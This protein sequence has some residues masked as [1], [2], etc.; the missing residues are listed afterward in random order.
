[1]ENFWC[2]ERVTALVRRQ[3]GRVTWSQLMALGVARSTASQWAATGRLTR[4]LPHVYA[5]GPAIHGPEAGRWEAALYAGP[6]AA[7]S[8]RTAAHTWGLIK[9]PPAAIEVST[10]RRKPSIEGV[11]RVYRRRDVMRTTY[12]GVPITTVAQTL[13]DLARVEPAL[14]PRALATLDF[15]RQLD[16]NELLAACGSGRLGS[17][18]LRA[19]LKKHQPALAY[20]NGEFEERFL[21][22]CERWKVPLPK[23]NA[24]LHGLTVDAYWPGYGLV[25]ELDGYDNHSSRAQLRRDRERELIL[26]AHGV[27]VVRYDWALMHRHPAAMHADLMRQL[28]P[29]I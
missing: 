27:R 13:L 22:W 5:I 9:Y 20:T 2:D 19:A 14:V 15:R 23:F 8:H 26:R 29:E 28:G 25:V 7:L 21:R 6:G 16:V 18:A 1:M 12:E 24:R 3:C 11:V 10:E 17:G 4:V